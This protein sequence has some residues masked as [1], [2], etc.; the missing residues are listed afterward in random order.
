VNKKNIHIYS[1]EDTWKETTYAWKEDIKID[2]MEI[3]CVGV[4]PNE[5]AHRIVR[6]DMSSWFVQ[7]CFC[8]AGSFCLKKLVP[9]ATDAVDV[10]E[11]I[12][13][14]WRDMMKGQFLRCKISS[15]LKMRW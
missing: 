15:S 1:G 6:W 5:M 12:R 8:S 4:K 3:G 9:D 13:D 14:G 7:L 10:Y 11:Y 2:V